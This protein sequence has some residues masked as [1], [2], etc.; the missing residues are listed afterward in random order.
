MRSHSSANV[1]MRGIVERQAD[2]VEVAA[3]RVVR[4][5]ELEVV[6]HLRQPIDVVV[7]ERERL[8]TSRAALRLR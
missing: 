5:G 1:C 3:E 8:P 6:H 7:C 4:I 2:V